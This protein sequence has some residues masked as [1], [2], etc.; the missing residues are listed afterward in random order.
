MIPV[1]EFVLNPGYELF[2]LGFFLSL[3]PVEVNFILL[4]SSLGGR[5]AI[6]LY[7]FILFY[8]IYDSGF[9]KHISEYR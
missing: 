3:F 8:S 4:L 7:L 1:G 2:G 9:K 6:I 5:A